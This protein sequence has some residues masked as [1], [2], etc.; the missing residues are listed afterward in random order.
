VK[1]K[2]HESSSA[3]QSTNAFRPERSGEVV[4]GE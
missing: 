3:R 1:C 4:L 2:L